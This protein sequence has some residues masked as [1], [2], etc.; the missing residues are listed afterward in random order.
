M[1]D[2]K[3]ILIKF[4]EF[5]RDIARLTRENEKLKKENEELTEIEKKFHIYC[6]ILDTNPDGWEDMI[7]EAGYTRNEDG[8]IVEKEEIE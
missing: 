6:E 1:A 2:I 3:A 7:G 5:E 8:M 4:V